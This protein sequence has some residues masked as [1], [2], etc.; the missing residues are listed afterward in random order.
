M[1][2]KDCFESRWKYWATCASHCLLALLERTT[3]LTSL[4]TPL[5]AYAL[6]CAALTHSLPRSWKNLIF[7]SHSQAVWIHSAFNTCVQHTDRGVYLWIDREIDLLLEIW[8]CLMNKKTFHCKWQFVILGRIL[9]HLALQKFFH[10]ISVFKWFS[11]F[12]HFHHFSGAIDF[13]S[14]SYRELW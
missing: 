14:L 4:L 10:A 9:F 7:M 5:L 11:F 3:M 2:D 1:E 6:C 8:T 13:V 12:P